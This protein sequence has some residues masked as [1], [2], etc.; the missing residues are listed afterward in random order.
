V[1]TV[2][3]NDSL[4]PCAETPTPSSGWPSEDFT[5][6][7]NVLVFGADGSADCDELLC[8]QEKTTSDA[9]TENIIEMALL[10]GTKRL[11]SAEKK[12]L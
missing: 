5:V 8:A 9:K 6:P 7:D 11:R 1:Y 10:L 4:A 12:H 2:V 3:V